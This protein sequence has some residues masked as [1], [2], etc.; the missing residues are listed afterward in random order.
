MTADDDFDLPA[1][2]SDTVSSGASADD[3]RVKGAAHAALWLVMENRSGQIEQRLIAERTRPRPRTYTRA[4]GFR[5]P[6][7]SIDWPSLRPV[8]TAQPWRLCPVAELAA[9]SRHN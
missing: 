2:E 6:P 9:P 8:G 4:R 1:L 7:R 5:S 3:D